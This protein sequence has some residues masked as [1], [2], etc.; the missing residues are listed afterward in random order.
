M[1]KKKK[2]MNALTLLIKLEIIVFYIIINWHLY[3]IRI[4]FINIFFVPQALC[5]WNSSHSKAVPI[6]KNIRGGVPHLPV[7]LK[8]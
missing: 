2:K 3:Y 5:Y 6:P 1:G 4:K 8:M 7:I